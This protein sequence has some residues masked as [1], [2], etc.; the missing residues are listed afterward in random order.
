MMTRRAVYDE[1]LLQ[2]AIDDA[3]EEHRLMAGMVHFELVIRLYEG[4]LLLFRDRP[5]V[6]VAAELNW[7]LPEHRVAVPDIAVVFGQ[8]ADDRPRSYRQ[9]QGRPPAD[10]VIE[11][12][13]SQDTDEINADKMKR[14]A[15]AGTREL[16]FL[17]LA[18]GGQ[19]RFVLH[20]EHYEFAPATVVA[21]LGGVRFEASNGTFVPYFPDGRVF[22]AHFRDEHARAETERD[23]ADA[24]RIR[25]DTERDRADT[26]RD[27]ADAL[28]RRLQELDPG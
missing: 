27:R 22:P 6:F 28:E 18:T 14:H 2:K 23:R 19:T 21:A 15:A 5:D 16:W 26:E 4:L 1:T 25:A 24:E 17:Y 9:D 20:D 8:P 3:D 12:V 11:V 7:V 13:S 10:L